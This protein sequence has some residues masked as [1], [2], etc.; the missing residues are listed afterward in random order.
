MRV[1]R[2]H[3]VDCATA[4]DLDLFPE[5]S[6]DFSRAYVWRICGGE[7]MEKT[8]HLPHSKDP[9]LSNMSD[10]ISRLTRGRKTPRGHSILSSPSSF[11]RQ[12]LCPAPSVR[13]D[14][15]LFAPGIASFV[16]YQRRVSIIRSNT[17]A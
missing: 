3:D 11:Q 14:P 7:L 10:M 1:T 8:D 6:S 12:S 13:G 16:R 9:G 15:E 17:L 4:G 2:A 5:L